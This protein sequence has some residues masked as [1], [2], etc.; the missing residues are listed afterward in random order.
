MKKTFTLVLCCVLSFTAVAQKVTELKISMKNGSVASYQVA[1]IDSLWF[2]VKSNPDPTPGEHTYCISVPQTF[3]D[4]DVMRVMAD[5]Q[6]VAEVCLEYINSADAR[7]TVVYPMGA[8][9]RADLKH[10]WCADNGGTVV[11]DRE[12]NTCQYVPGTSEPATT[13]YLHDSQFGTA[14]VADAVATQL[15]A[16]VIVDKRG[17]EKNIYRTVKIGTQYWM[18]QNL[19]ATKYLNGQPVTFIASANTAKWKADTA[20]AYHVFADDDEFRNAYGP[21]YNGYALTNS[22]GLCPAGW[23]VPELSDYQRLKTYL[24]SQ[25]G[26]KMKSDAAGA[27]NTS[28]GSVPNNL[29]GFTAFAAGYYMVSGDGDYGLGTDAWFWTRTEYTDPLAG[30][31]LNTVRLN[32]ATKA[33][34]IY[35]ESSHSRSTFG[36]SLRCIKSL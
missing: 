22:Q 6:Q 28:E 19:N 14:A 16:D 31:G 23:E 29:S 18:A 20:G 11:W 27:W 8:D 35:S 3:T 36:H 5:G 21:L 34:T 30:T 9:G 25:S 17:D 1:D 15:E 26:L 32:Y 13:V 4:N 33:L 12:N 2:A 7:L 24:G 10:G